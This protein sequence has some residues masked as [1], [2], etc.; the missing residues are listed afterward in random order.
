MHYFIS[1]RITGPPG[2]PTLTGI[3]S[4]SHTSAVVS[5]VEG[6]HGGFDQT[7][8]IQISSDKTKWVDRLKEIRSHL[9]NMVPRHTTITGLLDGTT[10]YVRMFASN[11]LGDSKMSEVWNFTTQGT[12]NNIMTKR[13]LHTITWIGYN[14]T[15]CLH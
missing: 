14:F 1:C 2:T 8:T 6:F 13:V 12:K 9:E 5:W 7:V 10:Y 4:I 15:T 11:E 3:S